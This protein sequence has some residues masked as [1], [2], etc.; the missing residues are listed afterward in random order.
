MAIDRPGINNY[1]LSWG[2]KGNTAFNNGTVAGTASGLSGDVNV[3]DLGFSLFGSTSFTDMTHFKYYLGV[4]EGQDVDTRNTDSE[5]YSAR[6]QVNFFDAESGL[7]NSS[8]Y[9][10]RKKTLAFGVGYDT[11]DSVARSGSNTGNEIDYTFFTLDAFTDY[12]VGPG[13]LTAEV[14]YNDLD[15]DDSGVL[16]AQDG[17]GALT[18]SA[19]GKETQ[20]SGFYG[21]LGYY[22][23]K[24]QPWVGYEQW[25]SDGANDAGSWSAVKVGMNYYLK[26]HNANIKIG[27]ESL[28]NDKA[29]AP[30]IDT[31]VLG[32]YVTY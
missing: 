32:L 30:D 6:V 25:D 17:G 2:A 22:I 18:S 23:N 16:F 4:F 24:W 7:F 28:T 31:F 3:R 10:G 29:G 11:Q 26:G 12:P 15:L 1:M 9:L 27:Y 21:Q 20:G 19:Q 5:R 13:Y 14:A 8:T